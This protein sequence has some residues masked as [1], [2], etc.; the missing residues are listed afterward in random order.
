MLI[1]EKNTLFHKIAYV[2]LCIALFVPGTVCRAQERNYHMS[3]IYT[4]YVLDE[5]KKEISICAIDSTEK[6]I[7]VPSELDGYKVCALGY[8]SYAY[9]NYEGF[10]EM[11]GKM[12]EHME[13]LVIPPSVRT[14]WAFAFNDCKRLSKV[15]FPEGITLGYASFSGC[16]NWKDIVLP[17]HTVCENGSLSRYNT[18]TL[19][20]SNSITGEQIFYGT[21]KKMI[22]SVKKDTV[23]SLAVPWVSV[24]VKELISPKDVTKLMFNFSDGESRVK[25]LYVNGK[26]TK[27]EANAEARLGYVAEGRVSFGEIDTVEGA[28]AI[29]F[30]KKNKIKYRV[31]STSTAQVKKVIRKKKANDFVHT[32]KTADTTILSC[33][34]DKKEKTWKKSSKKVSTVYEI[35]GKM[36]KRGKY[37]QIGTT[38]EKKVR[39]KYKYVKVKPVNEW[40]VIVE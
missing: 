37:K 25:K 32:W 36:G 38:K 5:Q 15:S 7:I 26:Q 29:R 13:E 16:D 3:G 28:E 33:R 35:Y 9:D 14:V 40:G 22:L 39:T 27:I 6:K 18:N 11:G 19:Q 2:L 20:I 12:K 30:A 17:Y 34:Y 24:T 8:E 23:F 31:K 10:Q 1:V 21:I 4:Y